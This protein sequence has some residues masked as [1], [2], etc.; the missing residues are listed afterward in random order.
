MEEQQKEKTALFRYGVISEL[1]GAT[2]LDYGDAEVL[3]RQLASRRWDI[4]HSLRTSISASTI[5]RWVRLY[6]RSGQDYRA[7]MP[8]QRSDH[9]KCRVVDAETALSLVKL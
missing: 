7:P 4:P 9:G 3:I 8:T 5:R 1:V 6:E 2:H